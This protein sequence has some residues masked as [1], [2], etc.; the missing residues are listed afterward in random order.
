MASGDSWWQ[1]ASVGVTKDALAALL[2]LALVS[3][4]GATINPAFVMVRDGEAVDWLLF[5]GGEFAFT[6]AVAVVFGVPLVAV[7]NLG[8][9][10]GAR[11][12][13]ALAATLV[14]AAA[15]AGLMRYVLVVSTNDELEPGFSLTLERW[16]AWATRYGKLAA[17][18][19]LVFE[20]QRHGRRSEEAMHRAELDR[21][22]LDREMQSARL[23]VLQAQ[24][25]PHFLFNTLA[26]VRRMYRTDLA[27][28]RTMLDHLMRYLE[29]ALPRMRERRSTL[30]RERALVEAYLN[31]QAIRMGRRL[32][33]IVDVPDALGDVEVPPVMLL[34]LV[35]NAI[36]HGLNP[37]PE[38]G[39]I[40]VRARADAEQLTIEVADSG[41][42][43]S[44]PGEEGGTGTGLANIRARL[45]A[46]YGERAALELHDHLPRGVVAT[47]RLPLA[48]TA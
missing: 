33:F 40:E 39:L 37:L 3:S 11:R 8:A 47:L 34:T 44:A 19:T 30:R 48:A 24:I 29:V 7:G 45:A 2:A 13:L 1:R 42:G 12:W 25:E 41:R 46:E 26:N 35:E 21:E 18:L 23:Q 6:C 4:L 15:V 14:V 28:G 20:F 10:K 5:F 17:L 9:P 32:R 27:G 31:V 16:V 43:L 36:K 38:G 22:A